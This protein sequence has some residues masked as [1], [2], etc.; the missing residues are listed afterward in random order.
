MKENEK[1]REKSVRA[2]QAQESNEAK[3]INWFIWKANAKIQTKSRRTKKK[4]QQF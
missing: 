3:R 1:A 4:W 2:F